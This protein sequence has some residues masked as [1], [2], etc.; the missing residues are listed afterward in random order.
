MER[1]NDAINYTSRQPN[2]RFSVLYMDL[3]QFK[4]VND[5]LGHHVGDE[6]L[7]QVSQC[8]LNAVREVDVVAR[9]GGD[10]FVILLTGVEESTGADYVAQRVHKLLSP[11]LMLHGNEVRASLSIGISMSTTGYTDA[12]S[13][14]RDA[15]RAM[16]AAKAKGKSQ[17]VVFH[18]RLNRDK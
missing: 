8:L 9:I 18:P 15:D 5:T 4:M 7:K 10:E 1:L 6:L 17:S 11:L 2:Y 12:L 14:L 16:Y 3:D 13:M